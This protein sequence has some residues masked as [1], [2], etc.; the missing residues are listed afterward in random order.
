MV[1]KRKIKATRPAKPAEKPIDPSAR[2]AFLESVIIV[3][4]AQIE[5]LTVALSH[6]NPGVW[7]S[8]KR[9]YTQQGND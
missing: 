5:S 3:R 7:E 4:D 2:I 8:I 6:A 1:A 9:W